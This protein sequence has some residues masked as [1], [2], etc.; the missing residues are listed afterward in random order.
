MSI[1]NVYVAAEGQAEANFVKKVLCPY[2]IEKGVV[3]IPNTIVTSTDLRHGRVYKGG[4]TSY[5][6]AW[7]TIKNCISSAR[8]SGC[9][10]T[11]MIDYYGLPG[12][13]PGIKD[14][15]GYSNPYDMVKHV[16]EAVLADSG[17]DP[18]KFFP[19]IQLHELESLQFVNL[20]SLANEY[21]DHDIE[22]LRTCSIEQPY[23][24]L[25]NNSHETA[26]SKR[27]AECIPSYDKTG[28]V[29]DCLVATGIEA[30]M[31]VCEHFREWIERIEGLAK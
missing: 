8:S 24:E 13:T 29:V 15:S 3:L 28:A 14:L 11:T 23:P 17:A 2:F 31:A 10:A 9:F 1:K 22:P 4:I 5:A 20:D 30:M 18:Y 7:N 6:S 21:F 12:D 16:E 19:Y 26:P 25:I 27:I